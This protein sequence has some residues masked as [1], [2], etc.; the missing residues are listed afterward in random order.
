MKKIIIS[1]AFV[2]GILANSFAQLQL[3]YVLGY[4]A[5]E[6]VEHKGNAV[7]GDTFKVSFSGGAP[8]ATQW[9]NGLESNRVLSGFRHNMIYIEPAFEGDLFVSKGYYGDY[10][11]LKW[12]LDKYIDQVS[13][14]KVYRKVLGSSV[15]SV[16]IAS[17]SGDTR[18]YQ[19]EYAESGTIYSYTI[20]AEGIFPFYQKY[21]NYV[22]GVGFR[23]PYGRISGR[24]TYA[25]GSAVPN[26][27]II[28]ESDDYFGGY[29]VELDGTQSYMVVSPEMNDPMFE[30]DTAF[31]FQAWVKSE[32][33]TSS[34]VFQKG[35]Q[36]KLTHEAGKFTFKAGSQSLSLNFTQKV[37]TFL[38][39][40]AMRT[41]DSLKVVVLYNNLTVYST[42]AKLTSATVKNNDEI[43]IGKSTSGQYFKGVI[44]EVRLWHS[45]QPDDELIDLAGMY[46]AGTEDY[47]SA[48]YRLNENIGNNI[49][50]L[51]RQG[52]TFHENHGYLY[53]TSWSSEVPTTTQLA[54][55]GITDANGNYIISGIPYGTD[56]TVYRFIPIYDIHTFDPTEKLLFVGPGSTTHNNVDFI[57][58]ASFP[59][60]GTVFYRDTYFPLDGA[61]IK[62]DGIT[63]VNSDGHPITTDSKGEF[64]IDVP[65]GKHYITIE[66]YGHGFINEGRFPATEGEFFD[67]QAPYTFQTPFIDTT[68]IKVT[69]KVVGGPVQGEKPIGL[70]KTINNIG[71]GSIVLTT[72]KEYDL[73]D[74]SLGISSLWGNEMYHEDLLKDVGDTKYEVLNTAPKQIVINPD[75]VTGEF[76]TY[77]LPEKYVIKSVTAGSYVFGS[78]FH[79]TMDLTSAFIYLQ[80][81]DTSRALGGNGELNLV[82]DSILYQHNQDFVYRVNPEVSVTNS[83]DEMAF[84]EKKMTAKDGVEVDIVDSVGQP[85]TDYPVFNQRGRYN[86]KISVF[87]KYT[88]GDNGQ[89]DKVPV[90]DGSVEIQN[91]LAINQEKLTIDVNSQ[92]VA[93]YDF[94]GG[95][96]NI[97]QGGIGD[98][99]KTM[100]I[101]AYTGKNGV[102]STPWTY[103]GGVFKGYV[104]GGLPTGS[105][106]VTT[107]PN[108]VDMILRDPFGSTSFSYYEVGQ[109]SSKTSSYEVSNSE[110][111]A[112]E[113]TFSLGTEVTTFAGVGAGVIITT[114]VKADATIGLEHSETWL[115]NT[116]TTSTTTTTK[117]W[118]TS[119]ETDFVGPTA[120]VFIGHATNIVYGKSVFL[121]LVSDCSGGDCTGANVGGY[122]IG[123]HNAIRVNPK[124]TTAF[125]YTQ[126]HII[127]YLVPNLEVL[128]NY[129]LD[130]NSDYAS[131]LSKT[132][133]NYG[134]DNSNGANDSYTVTPP[135]SWPSDSLYVDSVKYYNQQIIGWDNLLAQNEK[136][137][138]EAVLETNYSFDG[139]VVYENSI[140]IE[141]SE[142]VTNTFEFNISPSVAGEFGYDFNKFGMSAT[143]SETYEHVETQEDGTETTSSVT[144][145]YELSDGDEGDYFSVDIKKP[146]SSTGPVFSLKG[147]QSQC[148]Y[149]GEVVSQYHSPGTVLSEATQQREKPTISVTTPIATGIPEDQHAIF[150]VLLGNVSET[151]DDVWFVLAVDENSNQEGAEIR[152]DGSSIGNGR[153]IRVPAGSTIKKIITI[154]KVKPDVFDYEN[155]NLVL[156]SACQYDPTDNIMDISDTVSVTAKFQPVCSPVSMSSPVNQWIL[157]T[158]SGTDLPIEI[159]DYNLAH[160]TFETVQFQYKP[161]STSQWITD[162]TF[163]VDVDAYNLAQ[164]PKE[165]IDGKA[166]LNHVW[167]TESLN[168]REYNVRL[169]THCADGTENSSEVATGI[170]DTKRPEVFGTPQP[171]DGIL[172]PNDD[173][174]ISFDEIIQSGLLLSSNFSVRGVL[175]GADIQHNSSL[176][177]DGVDDKATVIN[178][179]NLQNSS[180]TVEFWMQRASLTAGTVLSIGSEIEAGFDANNKFFVRM[181]GQTITSPLAYTATD[182]WKHF[183]FTYDHDNNAVNVFVNDQWVVEN[184]TVPSTNSWSE[185]IHI[186]SSFDETSFSEMYMHDLRIWDN[187]KGFGSVFSN[188]NIVMSGAEIGLVGLWAMDESAGNYA[189]DKARSQNALIRGPVWR[190]FPSGFARTFNG[191]SD[192][193]TIPTASSVIVTEEMDYTLEF[194]FKGGVQ[195]NTVLFSNGHGDNAD[196]SPQFEDILLVGVD[197]NGLVY[198]QNNGNNL[199]VA[200]DYLDSEWHHFAFIL[201][202]RANASIYMDGQLQS[203]EQSSAYGGM[204][205]S[206]MAIGARMR[207]VALTADYDQYFSGKID[208]FRIWELARTATLIE[209]D[210]N[211]KLAGDEIG[212][213]AY[214]PFDAYDVNLVLGSSLEDQVEGSNLSASAVFGGTTNSDV[215]NIKDARPAQ[216]LA[217]DWVVNDDELIININEQPQLIE[218]T[219]LEFTVRNVEDLQENRMASPV[220]WTAYIKKNTLIWG[221]SNLSFEKL[222]YDEMSFFVDIEN[223]GGVEQNFSIKNLPSWISSSKINGTLLP[224]SKESIEFIIDPSVNIGSYDL[225]I[226]LGS[227]FGYDE[228]LEVKLKVYETPPVWE[229]D[230]SDYQYSMSLVGYVKVD[231]V[232][233]TNPDDR[234][235]AF[236]NGV[237]R[238]IAHLE[239]IE[240]YDRYEVFLNIY[241]NAEQGEDVVF[242]IW[243][244]GEGI[245][246]I[247]V[248]PELVFVSNDVIGTPS[249]P[250]LLETSNSYSSHIA[251]QA[252]WKW[253]SINL[254]DPDL[255]DV[256]AFLSDIQATQ[257]DQIKGQRGFANYEPGV[258]WNGSMQAT[259]LNTTV[260]YLVNLASADTLEFSGS[261][262]DVGNTTINIATGWN[263]VG[264]TPQGNIAINDALGNYDAIN[265]DVFKSQYAFA[266]Y[267]DILGWI[268]NLD[269]LK[270]TEG[271]MFKTSNTAA[272]LIYPENGMSGVR[273][274]KADEDGSPWLVDV[275]DHAFN[276][277]VIAELLISNPE[278]YVV[279][280]FVGEE[281]RGIGTSKVYSIEGVE[282]TIFFLT[283]HGQTNEKMTFKIFNKTTEEIIDLSEEL[284]FQTN[285]VIGSSSAPYPLGNYLTTGV[286]S[287]ENSEGISGYPNPFLE[288]F[289]V[290]LSVDAISLISYEIFDAVGNRVL[291]RTVDL[292]GVS[293]FVWNGAN[294]SGEEIADGV[295]TMVV[296]VNGETKVLPVVKL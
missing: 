287:H 112:A 34:C 30:L 120:D 177:F 220:T 176:Y 136:E 148:P 225:S 180:A 190:V 243:N 279:G 49:Y 92:G 158:N 113:V 214:Y 230:P 25:G 99:L 103:N 288:E 200:D 89:E 223:I 267:D 196:F 61:N 5:G 107:G 272:Q 246:H 251:L 296:H 224:D 91:F 189:P 75:P 105:N 250:Q 72:Q 94:L 263:W 44:D 268:G 204:N 236:V 71:Q 164:G 66:K 54:V 59:V 55:K 124:F 278:N 217:F 215:P 202:R 199:T 273:K 15:D 2:L 291:K 168:D 274:K 46:I 126:N 31:T 137:K 33:A 280:V 60:F 242:K 159:G 170:R 229:V 80:E 182:E 256:N 275:N 255:G 201:S 253:I 237:C 249:L 266:V 142:E 254:D 96:P 178:G 40:T 233:S 258:G 218:K 212:L 143:F 173:I 108:Q 24:V 231:G 118:Q 219:V 76:V 12:D 1:L 257:G 3:P 221:T 14:F 65:I 171:A 161:A 197:G 6:Q 239:Y 8:F 26:V 210:M 208:E 247:N 81:E 150:E 4:S 119:A 235:G 234:V 20:V 165:Y 51:S 117:L 289:T 45:S 185:E 145:G 160:S 9:N 63:A 262:V 281:C 293:S 53:K 32:S 240:E 174:M 132:D 194:W 129:I 79:T 85:L 195:T 260:M 98:Y 135:A 276:M 7:V 167:D 141:E 57:D 134:T 16:Q 21:V 11:E 104:L 50:D 216:N 175:N 193:V 19:D 64:N 18:R 144:F 43:F 227:D 153:L 179:V 232:I 290:T 131:I 270:P 95:L 155:I 27:N 67:F 152:L 192:V 128:R 248:T 35:S 83:S 37:D 86:L 39:V 68:L 122:R 42:S 286:F 181:K 139:G 163:Y 191:S 271:Y 211:S 101:I 198:V 172:S 207:M 56:G 29:S 125:M 13:A 261:K 205:G 36:Y 284:T 74:D 149:E 77:L 187:A 133:E 47:L 156:H 127:N 203:F 10:V 292:Q 265:G 70:G 162:M 213:K 116:T 245:E 62:V 151:D 209:M 184:A 277:S 58:I 41:A 140:T 88:N 206:F 121:N 138:L 38:H 69:G 17:V 102:I 84:W 154:E 244:A 222:L 109:S 264:F 22:N 130:N 28:A 110:A 106:F 115:D 188:M 169:I 252:G 78:E 269:F 73:T 48:Y 295:Y 100:T 147:G 259:G 241:S 23:V 93:T 82:Y 228:K 52:F 114:G 226:Y 282:E 123:K 285:D 111:G 183:A 166:I 157:N 97:T 186:G 294:E 90:T 238:G 283:L 87:E 146:K